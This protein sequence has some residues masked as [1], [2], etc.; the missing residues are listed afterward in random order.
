M[1]AYIC[2]YTYMC[3]FMICGY[4]YV[5]M[6]I[7]MH[8]QVG[9][10]AHVCAYWSIDDFRIYVHAYLFTCAHISIIHARISHMC[11]QRSSAR[12]CMLMRI[13]TRVRASSARI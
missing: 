6:R 9:A 11:G 3:I 13:C 4:T 10:Y 7:R 5:H 12:T 8:A 2:I 1:Y